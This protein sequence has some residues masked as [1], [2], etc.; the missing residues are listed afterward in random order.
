MSRELEAS[1]TPLR[2]NILLGECA[3]AADQWCDTRVSRETALQQLMQAGAEYYRYREGA[4]DGRVGRPGALLDRF[5]A[6]TSEW[7]DEAESVPLLESTYSGL[8]VTSYTEFLLDEYGPE[9]RLEVAQQV[10][11]TVRQSLFEASDREEAEMQYRA[12]RQRLIEEPVRPKI[13]AMT[14]AKA[15][16]V[17]LHDLFEVHIPAS[18]LVSVEEEKVCVPCSRCGYPLRRG[19]DSTNGEP[20]RLS[21]QSPRCAEEGA[22]V[23]VW[24]DGRCRVGAG[25][26]YEAPPL[27][28]ADG[29]VCLRRGIWRYTVLPGLIEVELRDRLEQKSDVEVTMWPELD[30]YDLRVDTPDESYQV[31][32]KDWT[33][34]RYSIRRLPPRSPDQPTMHVVVPDE[35]ADHLST[36]K[37]ADQPPGYHVET[38]KQFVDRIIS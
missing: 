38:M 16:G 26:S 21:C 2:A 37:E 36:L 34:P 25:A 1:S 19:Q 30:A 20:V 28:E 24:T 17:S 29:L 31:D 8:Q 13:E 32:V 33:L 6:P 11:E 27:R 22:A 7:I 10:V 9:P 5:R 23:D 3:R 4:V 14:F 18:C 12:F 35:R 15:H